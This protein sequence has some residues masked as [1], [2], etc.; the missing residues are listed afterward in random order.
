MDKSNSNTKKWTSRSI[1]KKWQHGFFYLLIR[2]CGKNLAYTFMAFVVFYYVLACPSVRRRSSHYLKRRFPNRSLIGYLSDSYRLAFAVGKVLID[3]AAL[4]IV[5]PETTR[6]IFYG[7]EDLV[8]IL[9]EGHGLVLVTA[10]VGCWQLALSSLHSLNA[11]VSVLMHREDGDL[12]KQY[13]EH[14]GITPPYQIIDSAG[15][16]G[17]AL[18]MLHVLKCG[19]ILCMMGDRAM[20]SEKST[21]SVEFLG[22]FIRIPYSPYQVASASAAPLAVV[23]SSDTGKG[24]YELKVVRIL[25]VPAHLGRNPEAYRPYTEKFAQELSMFVTQHPYQFFNFYDMW[26]HE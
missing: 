11:N 10:H 2:I 24:D 3:R 26:S 25:R 15:Y 16:L 4:G 22:G 8:Q 9:A 12:D 5:G 14:S 21:L 18:E 19:G 17:G 20:G 7:R 1:G 23:L 13:F 6:I